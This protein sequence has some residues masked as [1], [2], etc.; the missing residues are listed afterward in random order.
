MHRVR[1]SQNV[2]PCRRGESIVTTNIVCL[3]NRG[4]DGD[5]EEDGTID[6]PGTSAM[7]H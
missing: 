5:P 1:P 4:G 3:N 2:F 7:P 6:V